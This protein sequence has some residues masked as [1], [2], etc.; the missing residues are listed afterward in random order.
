MNITGYRVYALARGS[1][2]SNCSNKCRIS[3]EQQNVESITEN[4]ENTDA[5]VSSKYGESSSGDSCSTIHWDLATQHFN[6]K[7]KGKLLVH[8][9]QDMIFMQ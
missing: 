2:W 9:T 8:F 4:F 3:G 1:I 7:T 6:K 5:A